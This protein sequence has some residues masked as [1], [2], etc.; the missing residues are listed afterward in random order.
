M[1]LFYNI[2]RW[3]RDRIGGKSRG[4]CGLRARKSTGCSVSGLLHLRRK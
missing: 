4:R 1:S 3:A 2:S